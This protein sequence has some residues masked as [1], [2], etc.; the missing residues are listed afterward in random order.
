MRGVLLTVAYEG[1]GF[2]G[3]ARQRAGRTVEETLERAIR[4]IDPEA[5]APRGASRTDAGVHADGQLAAFDATRSIDARGWVLALN[6][7]LDD[8]VAVRR[9]REVRT[10]F[11]PRFAARRK[12]YRY[13][14]LVDEVRDPS[15]RHRTW[16]V[17]WALDL[18]RM[19]REG[20]RL[21]GT[22]DFAAFRTSADERKDTTRTLER[23]D[24]ES[25]DRRAVSVVVVGDAF[26]HNM[27]R[28][29]VGTLVDVGRGHLPEG[30]VTKAFASRA[31]ADLGP[32]APPEG[33]TLE[34]VDVDA[35]EG[36]G[37]PWPP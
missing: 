36:A 32:T 29:V 6:S 15:A 7:K 12:R 33:L 35:G 21:A 19:R 2:V 28:I 9:A 23:V 24:V 4:E 18:E 17:S 5:T 34:H 13:R 8:D 11:D 26:L 20:A 10:G 3:W 16:R 14:L 25:E 1:A 27:V 37:A 30:T 31:R 22:H